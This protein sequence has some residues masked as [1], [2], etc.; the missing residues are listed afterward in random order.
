[1]TP[2]SNA[3]Q[4]LAAMQRLVLEKDAF[5][6]RLRRAGL[7][8]RVEALP[9]RMLMS[10]VTAG[11]ETLVNVGATTGTQVTPDVAVSAG[12]VVSYAWATVGGAANPATAIRDDGQYIV[13]WDA[14]G[15][16]RAQL[17]NSDGTN[18]GSEFVVN[19]YTSGSQ[20]RPD[21]AMDGSGDFVITWD[22]QGATD[23]DGIWARRFSPTGT[24]LAAQFRVNA[25]T[26][27]AQH[28]AAVAIAGDG[29]F[30]VSYADDN[31]GGS[32]SAQ[33]FNSAGVGQGAFDVESSGAPDLSSVASTPSGAFV[34]AYSTQVSGS[35]RVKFR[36]YNG[37]TAID[38]S[39]VSVDTAT[40][41]QLDNSVAMDA[42]GNFIVAWQESARD[43]SGTGIY[44]KRFFA[45]GSA[46]GQTF[47]VNTTTSGN[48]SDPSI[49][50]NAGGSAVVVWS[51]NGP[52]DTTGIFAQ[53]FTSVNS[54]PVNTVPAAQSTPMDVPVVFSTANSN[55][56]SI[57]DVDA[58]S[59]SM[60]VSLS[61][62]NGT[63]TLSGVS[64]LT[65]VT[66]DGTSDSTL[67]FTGTVNAINA[68]LNG[69]TFTPT[70]AYAGSSTLTITTDDQ[71][72]SGFG[73]AKSDTDAV[74]ISV[75]PVNTA[76]VNT[77]PGTQTTPEDTGLVFSTGNS[78]AIQISDA[79][80]GSNAV[81][82][83]LGVS[84]GRLTLTSNNG[85]T[86]ITGDGIA[87]GTMIFTGTLAAIN[88]AL[89]GMTFAPAA[90]A[91]GA[92]TLSIQTNDQGNSGYGG[93]LSDSDN[94]TINISAVNDAPVNHLPSSQNV[95][96]G[97]V[98]NFGSSYGA[99]LSIS[100]VDAGNNAVQVTLS[101]SV[102]TIS[103][104]TTS[105]LT[106][107]TG[108]G[109]GDS[110]M[111]FRGT[112]DAINLALDGMAYNPPLILL[113]NPTIDITTNDLGNTGSGGALSDA[114]TLSLNNVPA[115]QAP[116]NTVPG[117]QTTSEDRPLVFSS[118]KSNRIS[119]DDADAGANP[120]R[121]SLTANNG[122]ISLADVS[123]LTF[124]TGD[125][126]A[127]GA[128]TFTGTL[129]DVNNALNGLVFNPTANL[130]GLAS[131]QIVTNDQGNTGSGGA[132]SDTSAVTIT[133]NAENDAPV[134]SIP[135]A[136]ETDEDV[137]LVFSTANANAIIVTDIDAGSSAVQ[138]TLS[139]LGGTMTLS[140]TSGLTF[141]TGD[142][143]SDSNIVISGTLASINAALNGMAFTPTANY[144]GHASI[145]V[146]INDGGNSGAGGALT[147]SGL[148]EMSVAAVNDAPV[149]TVPGTL[150][151]SED[152]SVTINGSTFQIADTD[153]GAGVMQV[154]IASTSGTM[155]LSQTNGLTFLSG[156]GADDASMVFTGTIADINAALN[157][158]TFAADANFNG[159]AGV[160]ITTSDLGASG[161]GGALTDTDGF[162]INV[163]AVNDAPTISLPPTQQTPFGASKV[164]DV[165]SSNVITLSDV[166][167]N[168]G[169]MQVMLTA[170]HGTITLG[171]T[172]SL[173]FASGDGT[174][175]GAMILTGQLADLNAALVGLVFMPDIGFDGT[176]QLTA[177]VNDQGNSGAGGSK[178]A[179]QTLNIT[180][181]SD[182]APV[183]LAD[184][185]TL[186][187]VENDGAVII[188]PSLTV[189]D[190]DSSMLTGATVA[191]INHVGGE[192]A[193]DFTDQNGITG[194]FNTT[195]GE[196]T[197]TG[198][199][200]IADYEI[201]LRSVAY[202][203]SSFN[204]S[205]AARFIRFT[206]NDGTLDSNAADRALAV[207]AVNNAPTSSGVADVSASED[208]SPVKIDIKATASDVDDEV[209]SLTY[210]I[211]SN[212][213]TALFSSVVLDS[214]G[215][216]HLNYAANA[217]G[218]ANFV[219][220][221]NSS[222]GQF[223]DVP[224]DVI[225]ASVNDN[226]VA[227][228]NL[229][230]AIDHD[231]LKPI[232]NT[233][234]SLTDVDNSAS[235]LQATL[236]STPAHGTLLLNG[237]ALV[238]GDT[239]TQADIDSGAL[240]FQSNAG[241]DAQSDSFSFNVTDSAGGMLGPVTFSIG[242]NAEPISP[243]VSPPPPPPPLPP[244]PP[245]A[246]IPPV[247][248][249]T[250]DPTAIDGGGQPS[251][252]PP[253]DNS[254]GDVID[255]TQTTDAQDT[256]PVTTTANDGTTVTAQSHSGGGDAP[257][258]PA[259]PPPAA[260]EPAPAAP[261]PVAKPE[262]PKAE[263]PARTEP[264]AEAPPPLAI[265]PAPAPVQTNT[266]ISAAEA[267]AVFLQSKAAAQQVAFVS[268]PETALVKE[269]DELKDAVT[270][271][272]RTVRV[273]AETMSVASAGASMIYLLWTIRG[274]YLLASL[275]SSMP[276]WRLVDPLPILDHFDDEKEQ[277]RKKRDGETDDESLESLAEGGNNAESD[278]AARSDT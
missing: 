95:S 135:S 70:S 211:L 161:A 46:D 204:P 61:V 31:S 129:A 65:F 240:Q 127:D 42:A 196:L 248:T 143:T 177:S 81:K 160:G 273:V 100:D 208:D 47:R 151:M 80:A 139:S 82:V 216:L 126:T 63:L 249:P 17:H 276:A 255:N 119:V 93:A 159:F 168:A 223:V 149:N 53:Q 250:I 56:I 191:I 239:F 96:G 125:G 187:Y 48:Q 5:R 118:A 122:K 37:E 183:V 30:F 12:G 91:S 175:D 212:S 150:T 199:A 92:V 218:T 267:Q 85:L 181:D 103:L 165:G 86:F 105:G 87:D 109:S 58:G 24:P 209:N 1:M 214:A 27:S 176:A 138:L 174:N 51:G 102:G 69:M 270:A 193:L 205:T 97:G 244:P 64:G 7:R 75:M 247:A 89:D 123:G 77:V 72:N 2:Q 11:N 8:P 253:T 14:S 173:T 246:V 111:T 162:A 98:L 260:P 155:T 130:S 243:P 265:A 54:A 144:S 194:S 258:A 179:A 146:D 163:T 40:G 67:T 29:S 226:P 233:L 19:D 68:A 88:S 266:Q 156:D 133:V 153:A 45:G 185:T 190:S 192:D 26:G 261:A 172:A 117:A 238:A 182:I 269:M 157:G 25:S 10:V 166:D 52:G 21:V 207:G 114:D 200:S 230:L 178:S 39:G 141:I 225:V 79:D 116:M 49:A 41:E 62:T 34:V 50:M 169:V 120:V 104:G 128:M 164:F 171:S 222:G 108:N 13:V 236:L 254:G 257:V 112:V 140:T 148:I 71:G 202:R 235:Q 237:V 35:S 213:N 73:G 32:L 186:N 115:N 252:V 60:K 142:G 158:S 107:T 264:V 3:Q 121:I 277:K 43:G 219:V 278:S 9:R 28:N 94:V 6:A 256:P 201:A 55:K 251:N 83:I 217:Y 272:Q 124:T 263:A 106:F 4:F 220:R 262:L 241:V 184:P 145:S 231:A 59:G 20:Q 198:S 134:L 23:S 33:Y 188:D 147:E 136:P 16:I 84:S 215:K 245:P 78:N 274:G 206:V 180:I 57:S 110:T 66:G 221:I 210:A 132:L 275:L 234:L 22:G 229:S 242:I 44:A 259:P 99:P 195:T 101:A 224:F 131:I 170:S 197:L 203:N 232:G 15:D 227:T 74:A 18:L 268:A 38:G 90:D 76:P 113:S 137:P 36:R 152:G 271:P 189:T 154:A 167:V 228:I